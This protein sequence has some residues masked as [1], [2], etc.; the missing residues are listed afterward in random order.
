MFIFIISFNIRT[1]TN[2][3]M[4]NTLQKILRIYGGKFHNLPKIYLSKISNMCKENNHKFVLSHD[5]DDVYLDSNIV[6]L[7]RQ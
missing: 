2:L 3:N 6:A 1:D 5:L 7:H 4:L